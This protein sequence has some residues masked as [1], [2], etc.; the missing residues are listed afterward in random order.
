[1]LGALADVTDERSGTLKVTRNGQTLTVHPPKRKDFS[2]IQ[3]L[4]RIRNFLERSDAPSQAPVVAGGVNLLVV[5]D[6]R[7]AR[8]FQTELHGS[9][10]EKIAP[11]DPHGSHRHL[12]H[13]EEN[14]SGQRKPELKSFYEAVARTLR[15]AEK[16]LILGSSTGASSAMDRLLAELEQRHPEIA[17]R[18]VGTLVVNEQHMS[19]DQLLARAREVYA[20]IAV[21]ADNA[22]QHN[23]MFESTNFRDPSEHDTARGVSGPRPGGFGDRGGDDASGAIGRSHVQESNQGSHRK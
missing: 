8:I 12:H 11:Y 9:V 17:R 4:I 13:V 3:E 2:D 19:E 15:T 22:P 16:I 23:S 20:Q 21:E 18:V 1:M 5:I 14:S 7:E 6:H 10:P